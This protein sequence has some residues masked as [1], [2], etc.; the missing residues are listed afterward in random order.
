MSLMDA[1]RGYNHIRHPETGYEVQRKTWANYYSTGWTYFVITPSGERV[2]K[3]SDVGV[4]LLVPIVSHGWE[5]V[6]K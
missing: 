3:D 2:K 1:L 5:P 4:L 6:K